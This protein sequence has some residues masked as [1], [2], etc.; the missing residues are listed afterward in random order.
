MSMW[1]CAP[2]SSARRR[3]PQALKVTRRPRCGAPL[4]RCRITTASAPIASSVSAVSLSDSP[5]ETLEPLA[6]KLMTSADSRLAAASNEIRVRVESS[7]NR[8]TTVRPRSV[9]SFLIS[10]CGERGHLG[11]RCRG[12]AARRRRTGPRP[13]PGAA[14]RLLLRLGGGACR[15]APRRRRRARRSSTRTRSRER[16]RAGSCRRSRPGSAARGG[17]GRPGPRAG[18][19]A[20]G[21]TSPSASSAART[22][23]P[24]KSTSS[25]RTTTLPST[26]PAGTSVRSQGPGRAQPQVVAVHRDVERADGDRAALDGGDALGQPAGQRH[27]TGR[28]AQQDEVV[29]ALVALEDLVGDAGQRPVDVGGLEHRRGRAAGAQHGRP[30]HW[31]GRA[32]RHGR[33]D[34]LPRLS[35]RVV[36]GCRPVGQPTRASGGPFGR[37]RS[38]ERS[39]VPAVLDGAWSPSVTSQN[40]YGAT[41]HGRRGWDVNGGGWARWRPTTHALWE[42]GC[43]RS[44]PSRVCRCT[45]SRRSRRAAG[46]PS[47]SGSYERGD[48]AVT[49]QRLAELA[50]FY[51]V[52]V[53]ELLPGGGPAAGRPSRRRG[54]SS[55]SSG[56]RSCPA[57]KAGPLARYVPTIQSQRGDYN[58]KVLSVR[59]DD[60]RTLAVI[61]D[62]SPGVRRRAVHRLGRAQPGGPPRPAARLARPTWA[63]TARGS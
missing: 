31:T 13:R 40:V 45:A 49:V 39:E 4:D 38:A 3:W 1:M 25:T 16:G 11:R 35:G 36:K 15:A 59:Q 44:G 29:G 37:G 23:R 42:P 43:A 33:T 30:S 57:E 7:K 27:A 60:L 55:T 19:S 46:R 62:T 6:E 9:G 2:R 32:G 18:P 53:A 8:L 17:R 5:L 10:R 51:G 52:P 56:C 26:P 48:R 12:R 28:D 47:S 24:E 58:G 41:T 34:L 22:V 20:A 21:P 14:S 50:D 54:W 61:Y 63:D